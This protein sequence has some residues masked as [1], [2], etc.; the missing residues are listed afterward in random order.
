MKSILSEY[1]KNDYYFNK[2]CSMCKFKLK[3]INI[4]EIPIFEKDQFFQT[5]RNIK[6]F[7]SA[8]LLPMQVIEIKENSILVGEDIQ[9]QSLENVTDK[10][11]LRNYL[12]LVLE[13]TI[14]SLSFFHSM[15]MVNGN[16]KPSN[17]LISF[18]SNVIISDYL[19]NSIRSEK[20]IP[21]SSLRYLS[22]KYYLNK[23]IDYSIDI[24]SIGCLIYYFLTGKHLFNGNTEDKIKTEIINFDIKQMKIL[25]DDKN[26]IEIE[27]FISIINKCLIQN[28]DTII[29]L[30]EIKSLSVTPYS[31][32][33]Y[34][35]IYEDENLEKLLW[36]Q[37]FKVICDNDCIY[38]YICYFYIVLLHEWFDYYNHS[39][40]NNNDCFATLVNLIWKD[41]DKISPLA[42]SYLYGW[43]TISTSN[44][45]DLSDL[46]F[47]INSDF[48]FVVSELDFSDNSLKFLVRQ[49]PRLTDMKY[50]DLKNTNISIEGNK[51]LCNYLSLLT[52][53]E[54]L[55]VSENFDEEGLSL[56]SNYLPLLVNVSRNVTTLDMSYFSISDDSLT[57]IVNKF[58]KIQNV[59]IL[60][61][62]SNEIT[63]VGMIK[64]YDECS[65]LTNLMTL[66][67]SYNF[68]SN[69]S[70]SMIIDMTYKLPKLHYL[71]LRD[72]DPTLMLCFNSIS[73]QSKTN[74]KIYMESF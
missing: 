32:F 64:L 14:N 25:N 62:S 72:N 1:D 15:N 3:T 51:M 31:P 29:T 59:M 44:E 20:D 36:S 17:I 47:S 50:L 40:N 54:H 56:L 11:T 5:I 58:D 28:K 49:F 16:I 42:Q 67:L 26:D 13:N 61:L 9:L 21:I 60:A 69:N 6:F 7:D 33:I 52:N 38:L 18:T 39:K 34:N 70:M 19:L 22:P 35:V 68:I 27:L 74:V 63:D 45:C 37:C 4:S 24:W 30:K 23:E 8:I 57:S 53:L 43:K 65:K 71:S 12:P 55:S 66:D 2:A 41:Y 48:S 10:E 46:I 73:S